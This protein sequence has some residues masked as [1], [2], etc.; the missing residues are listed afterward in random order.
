[1]PQEVEEQEPQEEPVPLMG[2]ISPSALLAKEANR[3]RS[4]FPGR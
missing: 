3:E 4:R 1:M 2:L